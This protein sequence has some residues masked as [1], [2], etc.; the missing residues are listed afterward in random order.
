MA[1]FIPIIKR[2]GEEYSKQPRAQYRGMRSLL[3]KYEPAI[4]QAEFANIS[5]LPILSCRR[6]KHLLE[7]KRSQNEGAKVKYATPLTS[8]CI[9]E[10][11]TFRDL[12]YYDHIAGGLHH[13]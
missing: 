10:K 4:W 12:S 13:D 7:L 2:I 6:I 8:G 3:G 1:K 5:S 11:N 9:R